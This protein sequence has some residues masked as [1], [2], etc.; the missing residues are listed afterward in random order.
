M[1]MEKERNEKVVI[2][3]VEV[4]QHERDIVWPLFLIFVGIVLLLNSLSI[5]D[6][7]IW[8]YLFK[9]WPIF[10]ILAGVKM[11]FATNKVGRVIVSIL[12]IIILLS[13]IVFSYLFYTGRM[14]YKDIFLSRQSNNI[15]WM[16]FDNF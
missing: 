1:S 5:V 8:E 9:F 12:T 2:A 6:W 3:G 7:N 4:D 15:Q 16:E 14:D 10:L 13:V 11:I